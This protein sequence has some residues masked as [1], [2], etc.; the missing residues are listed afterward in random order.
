MIG[1]AGF[2]QRESLP[3]CMSRGIDWEK[4]KLVVELNASKGRVR[5]DLCESEVMG[6][7][8]VQACK[9]TPVRRLDLKPSPTSAAIINGGTNL[10]L[11]A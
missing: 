7:I 5:E 8:E 4:C 10:R 1:F 2:S 3:V 6:I 11:P 9:G